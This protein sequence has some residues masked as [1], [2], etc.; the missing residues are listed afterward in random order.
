MLQKYVRCNCVPVSGIGII[1]SDKSI[2]SALVG[3]AIERGLIAGTDAPVIGFFPERKIDN[4]DENTLLYAF[5]ATGYRAGG[6]NF[7]KPTDNTAVDMVDPE[8]LISY[9]VG[10]RG[11]LMDGRARLSASAFYYDYQDLQV[12]RQDV[13]NGI[14]LNNYVTADEATIYGLEMEATAVVGD[15]LLLSGT[16]SYN[17]SEY[18]D[19]F[20]KQ[21]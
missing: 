7:M 5:V 2:I 12:L 8:N 6:F 17:K 1:S 13:V 21:K 10:Y 20:S 9:E 11:L 18:G 16:Y 3:I 14:S 15:H 19:F 4:L